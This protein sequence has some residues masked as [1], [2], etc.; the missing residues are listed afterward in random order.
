MAPPR[1]AAGRHEGPDAG[2]GVPALG[3]HGQGRCVPSRSH[4]P[5]LRRPGPLAAP[6]GVD[7]R[8]HHAARGGAGPWPERPE[9]DLRLHDCEP[10][11]PAGRHVRHGGSVHGRRPHGHRLGPHPDRQPRPLQGA[12]VPRRRGAGTPGRGQ[13]PTRAVRPVAPTRHRYQGGGRR[14]PAQRLRAGRWTGNR[15]LRRQGAL[16]RRHHPRRRPAPAPGRRGCD[17]D[18]RGGV[19]RRH[20]RQAGHDRPR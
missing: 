1:L 18:G 13:A 20:L 19:Q 3:D 11:G 17:G 4:A 8:G 9:A 2:I 5:G 10:P 6:A 7:R 14:P 16:L 15:Q 12:A